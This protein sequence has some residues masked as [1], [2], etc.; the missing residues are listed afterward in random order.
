MAVAA[1][2]QQLEASLWAGQ[3]ASMSNILIGSKYL[4]ILIL[5]KSMSADARPVLEKIKERTSLTVSM[6]AIS[7]FL[8]LLIAHPGRG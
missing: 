6:N 2:R 4:F 1:A 8:T 5:G 3:A 7:L